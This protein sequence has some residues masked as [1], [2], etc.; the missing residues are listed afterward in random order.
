MVK[1]S[2]LV[3][4]LFE[5]L[6]TWARALKYIGSWHL[7]FS[8]FWSALLYQCLNMHRRMTNPISTFLAIPLFSNMVCGLLYVLLSDRRQA[9]FCS[10]VNDT[11]DLKAGFLPHC[12]SG[13][14]HLFDTVFVLL[15]ITVSHEL[16]T[17]PTMISSTE[18]KEWN[19]HHW[20]CLVTSRKIFWI[21]I[22]FFNLQTT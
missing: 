10:M 2:K 12:S 15:D 4:L 17:S 11:V 5:V 1:R 20:V 14:L 21:S 7:G 18:K 6:R 22:M 9:N 16:F 13:A 8:S 3:C 19:Q